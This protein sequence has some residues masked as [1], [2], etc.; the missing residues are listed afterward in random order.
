MS[1]FVAALFVVL[2]LS[3]EFSFPLSFFVGETAALSMLRAIFRRK[4]PVCSSQSRSRESRFFT[5]RV[6]PFS[7][8]GERER[9]LLDLT[10]ERLYSR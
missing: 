7:V 4:F 2:L 8:C 10:G 6:C 5:D 1:S 3:T 9:L